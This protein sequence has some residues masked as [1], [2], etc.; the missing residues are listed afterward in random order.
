MP[1]AS[2]HRHWASFGTLIAVTASVIAASALAIGVAV[3]QLRSDAIASANEDSA[4][5]ATVLADQINRVVQ[6][7][8]AALVD[9]ARHRLTA[10]QVR[11]MLGTARVHDDLRERLAGLP[12]ATAI[13]IADATGELVN[14]SLDWPVR[15]L[16]F[17]GRPF[18]QDFLGTTDDALRV[19]GP[20]HSRISSTHV[21]LFSRRIAAPDGTL[22]G[23]VAMG[24]PI[25]YFRNV[26]DSIAPL[27]ARSFALLR[28]DGTV[29]ARFPTELEP[30]GTPIH[31]LSWFAAAARGGGFYTTRDPQTGETRL[32]AVRPVPGHPLFVNVAITESAALATWEHRALWIG[33]GTLLGFLCCAALL[34][35]LVRK[36]RR[37]EQTS[38]QL[39]A[40]LNNMSHGLCMFDRDG[41]LILHNA[42]YRQMYGLAADAVRPGT[43]L[44]E[45]LRLRTEAGTVCADPES[46]LAELTG[47]ISRDTAT[48]VMTRLGDGRVIAVLNDPTGDGGWISV[49][50]DITER[51]QAEQRIAHM[52]RHDALTDLANRL[53]FRERMD[54][55]I[56]R[57]GR[58][59]KSFAVLIFDIDLFKSVNDSL[60]H[61]GGDA[62]L[63]AVAER[64]RR[65]ASPDD[66][67][68]RI[69]G[70]EFAVIQ[71]CHDDPRGET[72]ARAE[73][74]L[75]E[76]RA[77]YEIEGKR[78]VIGIS[79]GVAIAP[80][81]G[82]EPSQILRNADLA[83]YRAK[84][85]GRGCYRFF[86]PAMDADAQL[87][88]EFEFELREALVRKE[89]EIH[90]QPIVDIAT[91][92]P[93]AVE[94]LVRWRH[95]DHGLIPPDKFIPVAEEIGLIIP[96]GEWIL[97]TACRIAAAWPADVRLAVN[98]SAVQF[99]S[100]NLVEVVRD[101]LAR[102]GLPAARLELEITESVLL[103][104]DHG[105][106]AVLHDL[107]A[108]GVHIVLDDF[109]TGYSSLSYLQLFPFSKIKI[110]K[111]FVA[112][113][114]TRSDCAAIVCTVVNLAK[115]LD[116]GTTA[117]GVETVEQLELLRA[118]GCR[119]AQGWLFGRPGVAGALVLDQPL[120]AP[121]APAS[122]P[123]V[124]RRGAE[125]D[126]GGRLPTRRVVGPS[127]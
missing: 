74:L 34:S 124:G 75:D 59:G 78:I 63:E 7:I 72:G 101:A 71:H 83:L 32:V 22:G 53:L 103:Q 41:R 116:M 52:A 56:A 62:L 119:E 5:L 96:L 109:G 66:T 118:A 117:E 125:S 10:E 108:L 2:P 100:G 73:R 99:R 36:S 126:A 21:V 122:A 57:L 37:L 35:G 112:D 106:L 114:P 67:L 58:T 68:G 1:S 49:H 107:A 12:Q 93:C 3:W 98:L 6:P 61:S 88:R 17:R 38:S 86:E 4:N 111:S 80:D 33:L 65:T 77:P 48:H 45:L 60:G 9:L 105:G 13:V 127:H 11:D 69:G 104:K 42:R 18:H 94:A 92:R 120:A 76:L 95:P 70:D 81:D 50:E 27:A 84:G 97:D 123:A 79:I 20:L 24:V 121:R 29:L 55:A 44:R 54:E 16:N 51:T 26:Y 91:C 8:D 47:A 15:P 87:Q 40:A 115:A 28:S 82:T 110:D 19:S 90:F 85:D 14:W 64:L 25:D 43:S 102:S 23:V 113:L 89:F 31:D 30:S 46:Y 39:D